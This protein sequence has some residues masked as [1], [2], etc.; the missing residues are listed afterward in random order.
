[1]S[2]SKVV[3]SNWENDFKIFVKTSNVT[4]SVGLSENDKKVMTI[5]YTLP[6]DNEFKLNVKNHKEGRPKNEFIYPETQK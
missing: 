6:F 2:T 4:I 1:M 3:A 5:P